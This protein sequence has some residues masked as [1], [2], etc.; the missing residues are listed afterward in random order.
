LY[1]INLM[2]PKGRARAGSTVPLDWQYLYQ[3]AL[4]NSSA[5][6]VR[7]AWAKMA[8]SSCTVPDLGTPGSDG[9]SG[10]GDDSGFSDFRYSVSND[11]W[12]FSWQTPDTSGYFK[13]SVSPP[14][15]NIETAWACINLR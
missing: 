1:E 8:N 15:A 10:L 13:I 2:P 14:G 11:T 5:V 6:D 7:V 3:G 4:V 9:S 12:Q